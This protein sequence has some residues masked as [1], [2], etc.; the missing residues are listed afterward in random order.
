M[1]EYIV[2]PILDF[3]LEKLLKLKF[4]K[5]KAILDKEYDIMEGG[6]NKVSYYSLKYKDRIVK[7]ISVR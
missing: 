6:S 4:P 1:N 7:Y 2:L 3:S 5:Y